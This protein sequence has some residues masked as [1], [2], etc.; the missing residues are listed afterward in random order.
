M[1]EKALVG[2]K[3]YWFWVLFLLTIIFIGFLCYLY[4]FKIGLGITGMS[5]D[6]SWGFLQGLL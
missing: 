2:S 1:L 5:R 4:Q 6:V 3:K